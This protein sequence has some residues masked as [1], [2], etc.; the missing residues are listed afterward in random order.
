MTDPI[1][2]IGSLVA[3]AMSGVMLWQM[4]TKARRTEL[5]D[6]RVSS[7]RDYDSLERDHG[8]LQRE[9]D[10]FR[11]E[12]VDLK[13]RAERCETALQDSQRYQTDLLVRIAT[14]SGVKEPKSGV[15]GPK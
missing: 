14:L 1:S 9:C 5:E 12:I 6:V 7:R 15:K 8:R 2:T 11:G 10:A 3:I 4:R 13:K